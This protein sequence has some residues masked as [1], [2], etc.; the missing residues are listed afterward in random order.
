MHYSNDSRSASQIEYCAQMFRLVKIQINWTLCKRTRLMGGGHPVD[1][2]VRY[3]CSWVA[4]W[5]WLLQDVGSGLAFAKHS[6]QSITGIFVCW[7]L[8]VADVIAV[9][10]LMIQ[11]PPLKAC[12][13][14]LNH[15][16]IFTVKLPS[17]FL[18]TCY[19]DCA[20]LFYF[21]QKKRLLNLKSVQVW[22]IG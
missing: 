17:L 15:E 4:Y 6:F 8:S 16:N 2:L 19:Y 7:N 1:I 3:R 22:W 9:Y 5:P 18:S 10:Q 14:N 12:N 21:Y 11:S 20:G 13:S